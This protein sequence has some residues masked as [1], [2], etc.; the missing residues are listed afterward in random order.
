MK[1][2][3]STQSDH[4]A[5]FRPNYPSAFF[6]YLETI[7]PHKVCAWD[8]GTGNGQVA[9]ALSKWFEKVY[10]T[11]I[12]PNQIKHAKKRYNIQYSV[13]PAENTN[14]DNGTFDLIMV[15]QAI[16]WFDF[17]QFYAEVRRTAKDAAWI[18][19]I[20]YGKI[21]VSP[22]IDDI[23]YR[24]YQEVI[25]PYWDRERKYIEENYETIPFPF[26]ETPVPS[27]TLQASWT[28]EHLIGYLQTWSAVK[29]FIGQNGF[30]PVDALIPP[31]KRQWEGQ[32]TKAI[33]FPMLS[34]IGKIKP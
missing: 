19:I 22:A 15:A 29:K 14:F 5:Q 28:L 34:R 31:L 4:Y 20:G 9:V 7:I 27:F 10:A 3:F 11:D 24:F 23:I 25:G 21:K 33:T 12:S 17:D 16:H 1:D 8:C 26:K 13:Q 2:H 32:Q 6:A 30:N 18:A